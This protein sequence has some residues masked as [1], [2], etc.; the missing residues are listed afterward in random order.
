MDISVSLRNTERATVIGR[1]LQALS[2]IGGEP[3]WD[4]RMVDDFI[5]SQFP[6]YGEYVIKGAEGVAGIFT[7]RVPQKDMK[8]D[9]TDT[10]LIRTSPVYAAKDVQWVLQTAKKYKLYQH[11]YMELLNSAIKVYYSE[12]VQKDR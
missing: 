4:A 1:S 11:P 10:G 7:D 5:M 2:G 8:F 12:D 9:W 3:K 6:Y